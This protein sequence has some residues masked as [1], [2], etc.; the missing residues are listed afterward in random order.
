MS[1]VYAG[2]VGTTIRLY[3]GIDLTGYSAIEIKYRVDGGA[4][5]SWTAVLPSG[6]TASDG[7]IEFVTTSALTAGTYEVQAYVDFGSTEF[8]GETISFSVYALFA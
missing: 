5:S 3:T 4:G 6:M 1:K 7:Y 2:D 8:Y